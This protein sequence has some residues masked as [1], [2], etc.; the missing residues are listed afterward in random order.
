MAGFRAFQQEKG[1]RPLTLFKARQER[2]GSRYPQ[3]TRLCAL[4]KSL[5]EY[6]GK[7]RFKSTFSK[8]KND[9]E[10]RFAVAQKFRCKVFWK[11]Q[12]AITK[13]P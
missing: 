1:Q 5:K 10:L 6:V 2:L 4:K 13:V 8:T 7:R 12:R 11:R 3:A 9:R